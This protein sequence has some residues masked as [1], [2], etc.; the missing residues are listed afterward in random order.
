MKI[1]II[2]I[3]KMGDMILTLPIL[4]SL[5][6]SSSSNEVHVFGSDKNFKILENYKYADEIYNVD[7]NISIKKQIKYDLLL[8]FSPGWKS[9]FL[10]FNIKSKKKANLI[11][12]SR[13]K[14]RFSKLLI[15]I[16]SKIFFDVT[17][18]V[19][20]IN[21]YKNNISIHQ[22]DIMYDLFKKC[23]IDLSQK[24]EIDKFSLNLKKIKSNKK[25]CTIHLSH[26]WI[27]KYYNEKKFLELLEILKLNY[28]IILTTDETTVGKFKLIFKIFSSIENNK[29]EKTKE[30]NGII[31]LNNLNFENW[32]QSISLSSLVITPECGC[33]HIASLCKIKSKIIYD[34][35][36]KPNMIHMEYFPWKTNIEK[37]IFSQENLNTLL[38]SNL[39]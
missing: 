26:K 11:L 14:K 6:I 35:D 15:F 20:R 27:N 39:D 37:Y 9:L 18:L 12:T 16:F 34:A 19:N 31:I 33:T 38:T 29:F 25:I 3:D 21:N 7:K 2:R 36:N 8:N 22:T 28:N 5:Q 4:K 13:Y 17:Y 30:I 24:I 1:A 23:N 10:C 32:I